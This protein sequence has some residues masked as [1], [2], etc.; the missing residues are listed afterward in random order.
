MK[1]QSAKDS[2]K[3]REDGEDWKEARKEAGSADKEPPSQ[4]TFPARQAPKPSPKQGPQLNIPGIR[5]LYSAHQAAIHYQLLGTL[6]ITRLSHAKKEANS[7]RG[8]S[9]VSF[10]CFSAANSLW[11]PWDP[12]SSS[13]GKPG[14]ATLLSAMGRHANVV[15]L[16]CLCAKRPKGFSFLLRAWSLSVSNA[17]ADADTRC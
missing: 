7:A 5:A 16:G 6:A 12:H 11:Q 10:R 8:T 9:S 4:S 17:D 15:D 3:G 14:K 13:R 1:T 2:E